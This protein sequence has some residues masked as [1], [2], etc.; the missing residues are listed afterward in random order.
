[1]IRLCQHPPIAT[2][3]DFKRVGGAVHIEEVNTYPTELFSFPYV[4]TRSIDPGLFW[5]SVFVAYAAITA[6]MGVE[7]LEAYRS[8][9][10]GGEQAV[11]GTQ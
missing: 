8:N 3:G 5:E 10:N 7:R 4:R 6:T 2:F 11:L 9:V 1:M